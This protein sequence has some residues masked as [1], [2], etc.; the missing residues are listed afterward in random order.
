M[1]SSRPGTSISAVELSKI[2]PDGIEILVDGRTLCLPFEE[3]PW[4]R[5]AAPTQLAR[6]ERSDAEHL[7]WPELDVDLTLDSIEHPDR[8]PL[9][10]R[11]R[12][13]IS[14]GEVTPT[15]KR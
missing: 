3:F 13:T 8:Y 15:D 6:I 7:Y 10:S 11:V 12:A 9:V 5:A 4:F 2:S 14:P 1:R